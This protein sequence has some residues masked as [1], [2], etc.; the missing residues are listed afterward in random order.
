MRYYRIELKDAS[1]NPLTLSSLANSG[2][3]PGVITSLNSNGT[4]NPAAL[5]IEIDITQY[6]GHM[7]GGDSRS[8]VR[9]WGL[10]LADIARSYNYTG[11]SIVVKAGMAAGYPLANPNQ[12]GPL[13]SGSILQAFGNWLGTDMTLDLII[14]PA[15]N[16]PTAPG[17]FT[18]QWKKGEQLQDVVSRVIGQ[19]APNLQATVQINKNR[20]APQTYDGQYQTLTQ[21]AQLI[22]WLTKTE[23]KDDGVLIMLNGQKVVVNENPN[24]Q[25][26]GSTTDISSPKQLNFQ[27]LLG[28]VT[29]YGPLQITAKLVMRG[30]LDPMQLVK[31]PKGLISSVTAASMPAYGGAP[32]DQDSIGFSGIYQVNQMQHWGNFRQPDGLSWNTTIW[33]S[34]M[35][36]VNSSSS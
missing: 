33:C 29:W 16:T 1:G 6:P 9:I 21:F 3:E 11:G 2:M 30:D 5:N 27:D 35:Q 15:L 10:S 34:Q 23:G 13:V 31:F 4:T 25:N 12:Q 19:A 8:Y 26:A 14:G 36:G 24:S 7:S 17:N 18:F 20:V 22:Y 32:R 28:Q